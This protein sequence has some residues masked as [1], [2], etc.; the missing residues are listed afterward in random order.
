MLSAAALLAAC[1]GTDSAGR[2]V[3]IAGQKISAV[4]V[5]EKAPTASSKRDATVY[6]DAVNSLKSATTGELSG[7][8]GAAG[9]LTARAQ[10]GLGEIAA[11]AAG[12]AE[13]ESLA[14]A[15]KVRVGLDSWLRHQGRAAALEQY[16]PS[17]QLNDLDAQIKQRVD[18]AAKAKAAKQKLDGEIAQLE[19]E[20]KS[21]LDKARA[22][23]DAET[24][25]RQQAVNASATQRADLITQA[26]QRRR[27][28]DGFDMQASLLR[29]Q[30]AAKTPQSKDMQAEIDRL[31]A[32]A[33]VLADAKADLVALQKS[34][35]DQAT[36]EKA[37]ALAAAQALKDAAADLAKIRDTVPDLTDKAT[38]TY[39]QAITATKAVQQKNDLDQET[40]SSAKLAAAMYK[41]AQADVLAAR[42]RGLESY[43]GL[44][45][46]LATA[47]PPLPDA[48]SYAS[49]AESTSKEADAAFEA[50][51]KAYE[52]VQADYAGISARADVKDRLT[53]LSESIK[54]LAE[55]DIAVPAWLAGTPLK[56]GSSMASSGGG[57]AP[58]GPEGEVYRALQGM[59]DATKAGD[60]EKA[61]GMIVAKTPDDE[62]VLAAINSVAVGFTKLDAAC[63]SK[64]KSSL[65]DL[66][67]N[68]KNP[69]LA[70]MASQ[71]GGAGGMGGMG[72]GDLGDAS[73]D[74]LKIEMV[75]AN[76]ARLTP[77][78][79][80]ESLDMVKTGGDWKLQL[81]LPGEAKAMIQPLMA[82]FQPMGKLMNDLSADVSAGKFAAPEDFEKALTL[83][84]MPIMQKMMGGGGPGGG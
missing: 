21:Q 44:L 57:A 80:G 32:Q 14:A 22:E 18:E 8:A 82:I 2:Q 79:G 23:R 64:F 29:A 60:L 77:K 9:L 15:S 10:A 62:K 42:A 67:K 33:K 26:N 78:D 20:A 28:S 53:K 47:S 12:L 49:K 73:V 24:A 51:K 65:P 41:H 3:Q 31:S 52:E 56:A 61:M 4:S 70:G 72:L 35:A 55:R 19:S 63:K 7:Q 40:K 81:A 46:S 34:N 37:D 1:D 36:R 43:A 69:M 83:K 27:A 16:D 48:A 74:D 45:K 13:L 54:K 30:S 59:L 71:M 58:G 76:T 39:G 38:K 17:K 50:A 68:S 75:D 84:M 11:K 6:T 5:R 66:L 25:I